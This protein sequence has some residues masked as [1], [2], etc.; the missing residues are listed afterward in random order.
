MYMKSTYH[1][2]ILPIFLLGCSLIS[3][4]QFKATYTTPSYNDATRNARIQKTFPVIEMM[5]QEYAQKNHFP[6]Y[7]FGI[8]VD[9]QLVLSLIHI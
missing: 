7:A 3:Q 9:G 8:V 1:K 6:G 2:F 4:A 5:Y